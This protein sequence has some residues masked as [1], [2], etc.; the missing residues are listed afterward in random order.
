MT[1]KS[2]PM[3]IQ[4]ANT[5][6]AMYY[7]KYMYTFELNEGV[8][9]AYLKANYTTKNNGIQHIIQSIESKTESSIVIC[10]ECFEN[11]HQLFANA[12]TNKVLGA[13]AIGSVTCN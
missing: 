6:K 9:V 3:T 4:H 2:H 13:T 8:D 11:E 7:D 1:L 10:K 5:S 12:S